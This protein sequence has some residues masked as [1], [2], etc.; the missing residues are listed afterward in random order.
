MCAASGV[1]N[2]CQTLVQ[3]PVAPHII[4][5]GLPAAG[6]LAQ[7][8]VNALKAELLAQPVLHGGWPRHRACH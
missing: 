5:K 3:A 8:L 1:Y 6:L 7:V 2:Q 4:D